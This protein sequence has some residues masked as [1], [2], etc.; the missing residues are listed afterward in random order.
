MVIY[1]LFFVFIP[2]VVKIPTVK[3]K[4]AKIKNVRWLEVWQV[5]WQRGRAK[6]T[7]DLIPS[8]ACLDQLLI[9]IRSLLIVC[10]HTRSKERL[11]A[12]NRP[13]AINLHY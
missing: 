7:Y 6:D 4:K 8:R 1:L 2:Q 12:I 10:D 11:I 5:N 9:A 3:N 13:I